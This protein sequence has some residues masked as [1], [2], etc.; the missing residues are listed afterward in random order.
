MIPASFPQQTKVLQPSGQQYSKETTS[1]VD[2]L[3]IW[4]NGEACVSLWRPTWRERFS[5]LFFGRVW[6]SVLSGTT[7]P[8][9]CVTG[10]R[11][12]FRQATPE[13]LAAEQQRGEQ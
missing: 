11:S 5:I 1:G 12:Y 3:P 13:E 6:L 10:M 8:P 2:P 7:Q 4:T 9:V